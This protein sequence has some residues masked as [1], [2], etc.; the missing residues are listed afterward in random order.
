M[1]IPRVNKGKGYFTQ[2]AGTAPFSYKRVT[3][4]FNAAQQIAVLYNPQQ[5]VTLMHSALF[6]PYV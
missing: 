6:N 2:V 1:Y 3:W 5:N 4:I